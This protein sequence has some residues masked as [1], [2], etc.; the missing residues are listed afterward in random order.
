MRRLEGFSC[1]LAE[2]PVTRTRA[3][4]LGK[5]DKNSSLKRENEKS[6]WRSNSTPPGPRGLHPAGALARSHRNH[7]VQNI[8]PTGAA[9]SH[10]SSKPRESARTPHEAR[11]LLSDTTRRG[12]LSK[13]RK[14]CLSLAKIKV[15]G[16]PRSLGRFSD[17]PKDCAEASRTRPGARRRA[18]GFG[19]GRGLT[20][21]L[22][23][24]F[25][26]DGV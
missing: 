5:C 12:T 10:V 13:N 23:F 2:T 16:Q 1:S 6:P 14:Y 19:R 11:G 21:G 22:S 24:G 3:C 7:Q 17:S 25:V 18:G 15:K 4:G 20:N 8:I 26:F 9:T